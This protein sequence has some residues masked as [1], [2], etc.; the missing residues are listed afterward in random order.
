MQVLPEGLIP[1]HM[2]YSR[3]APF[4]QLLWELQNMIA[5]VTNKQQYGTTTGYNYFYKCFFIL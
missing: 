2:A 1:P 4:I 3:S 5:V